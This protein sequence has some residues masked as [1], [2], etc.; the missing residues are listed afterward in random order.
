MRFRFF[1]VVFITKRSFKKMKTLTSLSIPT[2]FMIWEGLALLWIAQVRMCNFSSDYNV[3]LWLLYQCVDRKK[4]LRDKLKFFLISTI[5]QFFHNSFSLSRTF[6]SYLLLFLWI[7]MMS[8][9]VGRGRGGVSSGKFFETN[10]IRIKRRKR[11]HVLSQKK[12]LSKIK[13]NT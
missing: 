6:R 5:Q 10:K 2:Q 11:M 4:C 13:Y 1:V 3:L 12:Y 7:Y 8:R 9:P